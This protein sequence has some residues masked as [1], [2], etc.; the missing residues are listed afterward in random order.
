MIKNVTRYVKS[1]LSQDSKL[2]DSDQS[3]EN[4]FLRVIQELF[5]DFSR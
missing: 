4:Y 2:D 1:Q 5:L 3:L